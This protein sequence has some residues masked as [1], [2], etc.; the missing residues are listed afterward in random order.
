MGFHPDEWEEDVLHP[1]RHQIVDSDSVL[2]DLVSPHVPRAD[3]EDHIAHVI[4]TQKPT[5]LTSALLA[6]EFPANNERSVIVRFAI[7]VPK[8]CTQQDLMTAAPFFAKYSDRRKIWVHPTEGSADQSFLVHY[9]MGIHIQIM[10]EDAVDEGSL[11][12]TKVCN[13]NESTRQELKPSPNNDVIDIPMMLPPHMP[14]RKLLPKHDGDFRWFDELAGYFD[15]HG[16]HEHHQGVV[17]LHVMTW[18]I[19]HDRYQS[20]VQPRPVRLEGQAITWIEDF[21]HA[22]RDHLDP[23]V[24]LSIR[25][26]HP[27]PQ[28]NRGRQV[29]C[30]ILLEQACP[31]GR[32]AGIL[33]GILMG[34]WQNGIMQGAFAVPNP[35][36][37]QMAAQTL[38]FWPYCHQREC[39]FRH[40]PRELSL[41][42]P[43]PLL[44]GFNVQLRAMPSDTPP[45][46]DVTQHMDAVSLMQQ[47]SASGRGQSEASDQ[48]GHQVCQGAQLNINAPIFYPGCSPIEAQPEFIQDLHACWSQHVFTQQ[49]ETAPASVLTWFVDHREAYP[50][51]IDSRTVQLD[52]AF[53]EWEQSIRSRWRDHIDHRFPLEMNVVLPPP[54]QMERGI[55]GHVI[56]IQ[57]PRETWVSNLVSVEDSVMTALNDGQLMRLV[58][59]THGH[60]Q[61]E[62]IIQTCG[63]DVTCMWVNQPLRCRA[64]IQNRE[65]LPGQLW[66]GRSGSSIHLRIQRQRA[67]ARP[68]APTPSPHMNLLQTR[69]HLR[70]HVVANYHELLDQ[71]RENVSDVEC[72]GSAMVE[73]NSCQPRH[74]KS[75]VVRIVAHDTVVLPTFIEVPLDASEEQVIYEARS[76]ARPAELNDWH[77]CPEIDVLLLL[78]HWTHMEAWHVF[79]IDEADRPFH[80]TYHDVTAAPRTDLD[81]MRWLYKQGHHRAV[82]LQMQSLVVNCQLVTFKYQTPLLPQVPSKTPT[83]WPDRMPMISHLTE[84]YGPRIGTHREVSCSWSI[85]VDHKQIHAFFRSA[86]NILSRSFEG[87]DLPE[88]VSRALLQCEPLEHID[89]LV[90]YADGSSQ[91]EHRRRPP[92][93]VEQEGHGDTW[94]FVVL[95]EQYVADGSSKINVIGWTAQPVLY[96]PEAGHHIGSQ[97]VGSETAE[98]EA[99]FWCGAWRLAQ[100]SNIPTMFCTDSKTA[101]CQADGRHG[102]KI[103]DESFLNLRAVFQGLEGALADGLAIQHVRGHCNDPWNDLV[104][105]LAK[106]ERHCS[107][108]HK[109]QDIDMKV[110]KHALKHLWTQVTPDAGLPEFTGTVFDV[111]P[112]ALPAIS[113]ASV[114]CSFRS[115]LVDYCI[116]LATANVNSLHNGPDGYS[117]KLQ[118]IR[119]QMKALHLLFLGIQES[120]S[121]TVCS[122]CDDVLRL[123]G[124]STGGHYGVELWINLTQPFAN[125]GTK[126]KYLNKQNVVVVHADPRLLIA[127]ISHELWHACIAVAHAPH[128][129]HPDEVRSAWWCQLTETLT[130]HAADVELYVLIDANATPGHTDA[131]HVG[132]QGTLPSKSTQLLRDFLVT[133]N[134]GLPGTFS[135]HQG[136]QT[137]WTSP[138]GLTQHC[139]DHV[140]VPT[141]RLSD[142]M[143]SR[144]ID[145]F[146]LGN[147][148]W[149]HA[150]TG[151]ELSW[152]AMQ[153]IPLQRSRRQ[154]VNRDA[155]CGTT[156][157]S[158]LSKHVVPPWSQDVQSHVDMHNQHLLACLQQTCPQA[159]HQ[160]KKSF[161]TA[162]IWDLRA[163]KLQCRRIGKDISGRVRAELLRAAW[164]G[165]KSHVKG[166]DCAGYADIYH[167]YDVALSCWKLYHGV[168]L[169][170]LARKLKKRLKTARCTAIQRD[171]H[172]LPEDVSA[173]DVLQLIKKHIGSTNLKSLKKP[174]LP[175]LLNAQGEACTSPDQLQNEWIEF[176]GQMEGGVRM[177]WSDLISTWQ[178]NL[179]A[180]QQQQVTLGPDDLPS[181]T[182]LEIAFRRVKKGKAMGQDSIPP[183]LCKACP[184]ILAKQYYSVL[185][186]LVVHGQESLCHKGGI[187]VPAFKGKG[188]SLDPTSYRSLLISSHMGKVL[189]RAVRQHQ[190]QLYE[191]FLCAQQLGG[192]RKVPVT[193]GL[194]EARAYLRSHQ[195]QGM[196]VALLMVDLTEAFYRVLRPLAVGGQYTDQQLAQIVQKLG[197]PPET[198]H[199]LHEHLK[200]PCAIAQAQLPSHM[201]RVLRSLHTDTYFQ[202]QGQED[203]CHTS[204]GSRPG[205]CFADVIFSYLFAR[206]MKCFQQQM[207]HAGLQEFITDVKRFEPFDV[208]E[209]VGRQIPY[210]GPVWMD[211]LCVGIKA[212]SPGE[213]ITKAGITTSLL[214]ETLTGFGMT[215]NLKKGKTE[216]LFSLRG[217]GVRKAKQQL[218]GP[219]SAGHLP[220]M[221][222]AGTHF[223]SVVGQYQHLG[224][225]LHHGGDHRQEMKRRM[226]IAHTA[227]NT[228]RKVIYQN[229]AIAISKRVQLF[230]TLI[231]SKLIYGCESWVLQDMKSKEFLHSAVMRL[232]RRLLSCKPDDKHSDD[233]ILK[234]LQLPSPTELLRQARLRYLGTLHA[235]SDVVSWDLLNR[236]AEW[237][238]LIR[239]DLMWMWQQLE[240]SSSLVAPDQHFDSWR[241]LWLYHKSY[242]KGLIKRAVQHSILQRHNE[243]V[244]QQGHQCILDCLYDHEHILPAPDGHRPDAG[245]ETTKKIGCMQCQ[246]AFKSKGGEGAHMFKKHGALS[247][248]RYL[249]DH[250]RCEVCM[251]EYY[252]FGKLHNHL[253]YSERCR[254]SLQSQP[255]RCVPQ[256]GHESQLNR[257]MDHNH[258]GLLPPMTSMGPSL[259]PPRLRAVETFDVEFYSECTEILISEISL[260]DKF[261]QIRARA[262]TKPLSWSQFVLTMECLQMNAGAQDL[263]AFGLTQTAFDASIRQLVDPTTWPWFQERDTAV[264]PER[265]VADLEWQCDNAVIGPAAATQPSP[266]SFGVHRF[267]LHAFSGR[268][269]EGDFQFFLDA[270]TTSHP[271]IVIHTLSVD[272]ILDRKWGDV[273]DETVQQFWIS[274]ARRGWVVAYLGGPPC[275]TWSRAR[276]QLL[277]EDARYGPRVLRSAMQP[278]G[279]SSLALREI[280]QIL[281]GN[282]LMFFS[283]IM[284]TVLYDVG[285]CGALEHPARPP[286][287]TSAS[288]WNTSILQLLL[289][290]PGF[291]LWEFAQGLLGAVSAKPTMILALN[292]PTLGLQIRQWRVVDELPKTVSIGRGTDGKFN[293]MVLK[294]YPPSLCGALATSFWHTLR[295]LPVNATVEIPGTFFQTC[296]SMDVQTYSDE[297]GPDYAGG[298]VRS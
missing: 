153:Q 24:L 287:S 298:A 196:S 11:F 135:C 131:I 278:W 250:T 191:T 280:R 60:I 238:A 178:S 283:L 47:P 214:L 57:A 190:A 127:K 294:E 52:H 197:M 152:K 9:G 133:W 282:Q 73:R 289:Q 55:I 129:G 137:T 151:T 118:Y 215:P 89:R 79:Y 173:M 175:M 268:R 172:D 181:L 271:G 223:V 168:Q 230:N 101:G 35:L 10:P 179:K 59:T 254:R 91:P 161:I 42:I 90:I 77:F 257:Q 95:A 33:T 234:T 27:Q 147:S 203:C 113:S 174:T 106:R 224:G 134:L 110:W 43:E 61:L 32:S 136:P 105:L 128:S 40:G 229:S 218:F 182:D 295:D 48:A 248:L 253:R 183:E 56:L 5:T 78:D 125:V 119:D 114:P 37:F 199:D 267:I 58:I 185:M 225:L 164:V 171:L 205:D 227:F 210:T 292:L 120:R 124:G 177:P 138:D 242:W 109:R 193:L 30:H 188:S 170:V 270:I 41:T 160:A 265:S 143:F 288:I 226:A 263:D 2:I 53:Q 281:V 202:V 6:L 98:R 293:T 111:Q 162:D 194:H 102:A 244:V 70:H 139:I 132:P 75:R 117:G 220:V 232:Y 256:Q 51:S 209:P 213:L 264:K 279:F 163:Q 187:L 140:C 274:A 157:Q 240:R 104:D 275:E 156:L 93:Q 258:D 198:L 290:L 25:M 23:R 103:S 273:S 130:H 166:Q 249:F 31:P 297:L 241:Y 255:H 123:G 21:R 122:Q 236:D 88:H 277:R 1:W 207:S 276:E 246:Q 126:P 237:C 72:A 99:M 262:G 13:E 26:I 291:R 245:P 184:T 251:K 221:S 217:R 36:S 8:H 108:Y 247:D 233:W 146:D 4:I 7:A 208:S 69:T 83:P 100:N 155:I 285:G 286:K 186:K 76:W 81:H 148:H 141:S 189:H 216:I 235:C 107:F 144:V 66:P 97:S 64:W 19:H 261:Q 94:A 284:M 28:Q 63:Y 62:H 84:I 150:V 176:F 54:P 222:E 159:I 252:T 243:W 204:V 14:M 82:I 86:S 260:A 38:G 15:T 16:I 192:R 180:F 3:I 142:C 46:E 65:L 50:T 22:W 96:D 167:R 12:Q 212:N 20:C 149:D 17:F 85:G 34:S 165:W 74:G 272:I 29:A 67:Q 266:R 49:S 154:S 68:E 231:L 112:P 80:F 219:N 239:D 44:S 92:A 116:S 169:H 145:E 269:R 71:V 18:Y 201:Q 296:S 45:I 211:D 259:P 206:V 121:S 39:T 228:H 195:R 158:G 87:L 115:S 200:Q